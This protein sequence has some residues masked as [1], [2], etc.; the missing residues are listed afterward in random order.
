[1][2]EGALAQNAMQQQPQKTANIER[3]KATTHLQVI[4]NKT[5][6]TKK[7]IVVRV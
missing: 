3:T 5:K 1:M 2:F 7:T 6:K 4:N